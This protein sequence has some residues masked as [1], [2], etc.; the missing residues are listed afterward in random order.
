M[1]NNQRICPRSASHL[2]YQITVKGKLDAQWAEW[3]NGTTISMTYG[4]DEKQ[5]TI[6]TIQIRDQS[7]LLGILN[8]L[9][10][11]NLSLLEVVMK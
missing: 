10:G 9:H 2:V 11:F 5:Q 1:E 4:T 3:F 7:E 6:F 8:C